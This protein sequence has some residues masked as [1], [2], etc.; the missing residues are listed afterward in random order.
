M[1]SLRSLDLTTSPKSSLDHFDLH[2]ISAFN[3]HP[4]KLRP[5]LGVL[6]PDTRVFLEKS[7]N[8]ECRLC[9]N[10]LLC[11]TDPWTP[12]ERQI[13]PRRSGSLPTLRTEFLSIVTPDLWVRVHGL[14]VETD[15]GA[16]FDQEG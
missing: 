5:W 16:F 7:Y 13:F 8:N 4:E 9:K 10:H 3:C 1:H 6:A 15:A 2:P 14:G 11:R 12:T